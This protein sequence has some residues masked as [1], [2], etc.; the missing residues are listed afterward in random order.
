MIS[1]IMPALIDSAE[2]QEWLNEAIQSIQSQTFKDWELVIVDD[3]SPYSLPVDRSDSRIRIVKTVNR[4]GPSLCRNDAVALARYDCLFPLDSDDKLA[5]PEILGHLFLVWEQNQKKI[6]YGDIQQLL[7]KDEVWRPGK[8]F[9]LPEYTFERVMDLNGI[10]PVSAMHSRECH[11]AAGGWKSKLGLGLEDVE[12]WI[13]AGKAGYCGYKIPGVVIQY[14]KHFSSRSYQLRENRNEG[15]MRNLIR[16]MHADIYEGRFPMGCCGGGQAYVPPQN[17]NKQEAQ[18]TT[19]D[20]VPSSSKVLVEYVG[21]RNGEFGIVGKTTNINYPINGK[22]HKF[23]VHVDDLA[24]FQRQRGP[25]G[26]NV[27]VIGA[28]SPTIQKVSKE[29]SFIAQTPELTQILQ[30]E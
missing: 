16:E 24:I 7:Y 18:I 1:I 2:K 19:L 6:I 27:F 8:V 10:I 3:S 17:N 29:P 12:Y 9:D 30:L 25:G 13:A 21:Q 26:Q 14:R 5:D 4:S 15:E 22:G 11:M 28:T 23:E 20:Q